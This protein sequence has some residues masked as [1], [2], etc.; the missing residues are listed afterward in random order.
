MLH[1][2]VLLGV[3]GGV[4]AVFTTRRIVLRIFQVY[5]IAEGFLFHTPVGESPAW[6]G[7]VDPACQRLASGAK[8]VEIS[9]ECTSADAHSGSAASGPRFPWGVTW[10]GVDGTPSRA[11]TWARV[12]PVAVCKT[13]HRR[14]APHTNTFCSCTPTC[15]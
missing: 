14:I 5:K 2:S 9:F 7:E 12:L 15:G 3:L 11:S 8:C 1:H 6:V 13:A 4:S 10:T